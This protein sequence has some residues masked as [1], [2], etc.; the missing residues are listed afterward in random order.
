MALTTRRLS[1][2]TLLVLPILGAGAALFREYKDPKSE[3]K[4]TVHYP[5]VPIF[6]VRIS[7]NPQ[8]SLSFKVIYTGGGSSINFQVQR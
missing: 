6:W 1:T 8:V 4:L 7:L 2:P 3:Q 5:V